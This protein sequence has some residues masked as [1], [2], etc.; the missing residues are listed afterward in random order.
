MLRFTMQCKTREPNIRAIS[1]L[2]ALVCFNIPVLADAA[3]EVECADWNTHRYFQAA[4]VEDVVTCLASGADPKARTVDGS[5][6]LHLAAM[7]NENPAVISVLLKAGAAI[8]ARDGRY[9]TP[10]HLAVMSNGNSAV[11]SVLLKA[12]AASDAQDED[13]KSPWDYAKSHQSLKGSDDYRRMAASAAPRPSPRQQSR[14]AV[15]QASPALQRAKGLFCMFKD[16]SATK[17]IEGKPVVEL[18]MFSTSSDATIFSSIDLK[19]RTAT[20]GG[21]VGSGQVSVFSTTSGVTFIELTQSG[22]VNITTVFA[23]FLE[24]SERSSLMGPLFPAV[25]SRHFFSEPLIP[26]FG[27]AAVMPS[28]YHGTCI[29]AAG[30]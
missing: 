15:A 29:I 13:G 26:G 16:G 1:T 25:H 20:M 10:L 21:N 30:G 27:Q 28:Q 8:N 11:I 5:T 2:L 14:H 6:P 19:A 18:D 23:S 24:G 22:N 4:T 3:P 9:A 7:S 17:W 12:G